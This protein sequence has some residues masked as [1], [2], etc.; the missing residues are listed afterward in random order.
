MVSTYWDSNSHVI[1]AVSCDNIRGFLRVARQR[2]LNSI[3]ELYFNTFIKTFLLY[4]DY[5]MY[6]CIS[7][8]LICMA[9]HLFVST[10][11]GSVLSQNT[12]RST[13]VLHG[14]P[15]MRVVPWYE[16]IKTQSGHHLV[17]C[18]HPAGISYCDQWNWP[19]GGWWQCFVSLIPGYLNV[20]YITV[21]S[22]R[23]Q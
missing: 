20:K 23:H 1:H 4:Y 12:A 18:I 22:G 21:P 19:H 15:W 3:Y 17:S 8:V 10:W 16:Y 7:Q 14:V 6:Y 2:H 11:C 9:S 5:S 13:D